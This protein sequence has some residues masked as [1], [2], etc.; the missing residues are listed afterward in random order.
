MDGYQVLE[1]LKTDTKLRDTPVVAITAN[2]VTKEVKHGKAA[3][4][5]DYLTKPI[6][7]DQFGAILDR[8]LETEG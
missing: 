4:F 3:G 7:I 2:A 1:V 5:V 8:L 6:D